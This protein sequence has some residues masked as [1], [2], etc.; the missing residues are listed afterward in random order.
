MKTQNTKKNVVKKTLLLAV[1]VVMSVVALYKQPIVSTQAM[2]M[3]EFTPAPVVEPI[4]VG[5]PIDE[6]P[7]ATVPETQPEAPAPQMPVYVPDEE[8]APQPQPQPTEPAPTEPAPTEPEVQ[9]T[10]PAPTEP[11]VPET[12]PAP[13]PTEPQPTE[14]APTEPAPTEPA[15]PEETEPAPTEGKEG[16]WE[17]DWDY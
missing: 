6:E 16:A 11:E 12:E 4:V 8:P 7:E 10:E 3:P 13:A 5:T 2:E 17:Y 15:V 1:M 14:P 9:P